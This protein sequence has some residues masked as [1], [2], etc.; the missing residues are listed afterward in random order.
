MKKASLVRAMVTWQEGVSEEVED[1]GCRVT[2]LRALGHARQQAGIAGRPAVSTATPAPCR[3]SRA[4]S[5]L[6]RTPRH[7]HSRPLSAWGPLSPPRPLR[8]LLHL[9]S[10]LGFRESW[11]SGKSVLDHEMVSFRFIKRIKPLFSPGS[12]RNRNKSGY[13]QIKYF[14]E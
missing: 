8:L 6:A 5:V 9:P 4:Q 7:C 1:G 3:E 12:R 14:T 2:L 13:N 11:Q 10:P